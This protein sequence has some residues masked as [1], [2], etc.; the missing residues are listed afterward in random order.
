MQMSQCYSVTVSQS[1]GKRRLRAMGQIVHNCLNKTSSQINDCA[2]RDRSAEDFTGGT[3]SFFHSTASALQRLVGEE[4]FAPAPEKN[5]S[6]TWEQNF[7]SE[8]GSSKGK[9]KN[10][11]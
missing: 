2:V 11:K 6:L 3:S 7:P 5:I 10:G 8:V 4:K 1:S 9:V